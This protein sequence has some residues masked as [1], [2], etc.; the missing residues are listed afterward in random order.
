MKGEKIK[1][2]KALFFNKVLHKPIEMKPI[3]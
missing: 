1:K 2:K 3:G